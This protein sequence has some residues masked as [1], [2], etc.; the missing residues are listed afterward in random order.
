MVDLSS[1]LWNLGL[2]G[3]A[4]LLSATAKPEDKIP[5]VFCPHIKDGDTRAAVAYCGYCLAYMCGAC[6]SCH[7][8]DHRERKCG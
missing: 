7:R 6:N 4:W 5:Y 1:A 2:D 8:Y 3:N